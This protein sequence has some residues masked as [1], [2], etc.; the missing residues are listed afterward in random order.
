MSVDGVVMARSINCLN[1]ELDNELT[2]VLSEA[3]RTIFMAA[4][5]KVHQHLSQK[6]NGTLR[7]GWQRSHRRHDPEEKL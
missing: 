2:S 6:V 5:K 4:L 3:E 7:M 1:K